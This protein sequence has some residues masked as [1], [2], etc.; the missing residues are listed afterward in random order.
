MHEFQGRYI[1][2]KPW[3]SEECLG[4]IIILAICYILVQ[5]KKNFVTETILDSVVNQ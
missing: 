5:N 1:I 4:L 3:Y 2:Q